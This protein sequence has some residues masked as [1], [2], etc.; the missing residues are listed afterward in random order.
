MFNQ[1]LD[2]FWGVLAAG[3]D[4]SCFSIDGIDVSVVN[5]VESLI[6]RHWHSLIRM[7][8]SG[9]YYPRRS[10]PNLAFG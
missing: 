9:K 4:L 8:W 5:G 6:I 10:T 1:F 7:D 3:I 2:L